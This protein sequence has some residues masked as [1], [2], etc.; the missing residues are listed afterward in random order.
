MAT[1]KLHAYS[2]PNDGTESCDFR[3]MGKVGLP[4]PDKH[5][6]LMEI[7]FGPDVSTNEQIEAVIR[8][9]PEW[10]RLTKALLDGAKPS[11]LIGEILRLVS[12]GEGLRI[13]VMDE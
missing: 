9:G 12:P 4:A 10:N 11:G 5:S 7:E 2:G 13:C 3:G 6:T 1:I 8:D